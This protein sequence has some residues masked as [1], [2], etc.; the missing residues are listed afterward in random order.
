[1]RT[2][3]ALAS[4]AALLLA[5]AVLLASPVAATE[6]GFSATPAP[7][8]GP[9]RDYL[10]LSAAPGAIVRDALVVRNLGDSTIELRLAAVDATTG[11]QG[12]ASYGVDESPRAVGTWVALS[13]SVLSLSPRASET[14][15]VEVRVPADARSGDHLGGISVSQP[16]AGGNPTPGASSSLGASVDLA[17]RRVLAVK[18][19]VP[20]EAEPELVV[21]GV[22]PGARPAG[23]YLMVDVANTGRRLTTAEGT[24]EVPSLGF[25]HEFHVGTFVPETAI[26]YPVKLTVPAPRSGRLPA[27][28]ELRYGD[29]VASWAGDVVI[30][31]ETQAELERRQVQGPPALEDGTGQPSVPWVLV[32][33]ALALGGVGGYAGSRRRR[34]SAAD[35][36][37]RP[38]SA[39][40]TSDKR[41]R[42]PTAPVP[43]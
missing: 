34:S 24:L 43:R 35:P 42:E 30:G 29:R 36:S 13:H 20:G 6:L 10:Q 19:T 7:G 16:R 17:V 31:T 33:G 27:A 26:A 32:A 3:R 2:R 11:P 18:L 25:R 5:A 38:P 21:S 37:G 28:V 14:V 4:A 8:P 41:E 22:S 9:A 40:V 39:D 23:L 1:M 12:G 15:S